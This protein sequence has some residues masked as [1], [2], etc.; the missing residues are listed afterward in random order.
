ME[1]PNKPDET[2][3]VHR[4]LF[5]D[6]PHK[7]DASEGGGRRKP[8]PWWKFA[9]AAL[10]VVAAIL[11]KTG[12]NCCTPSSTSGTSGAEQAADN[13]LDSALAS[14]KPVL[15][16]F[17]RGTCIPCKM[18]QPV[19]ESLSKEL[20]GKVHVLILD[21]DEYGYLANRY[22]IRIIPTQIFFDA[23]GTEKERHQGFMSKEEI[24]A[25]WKE[26]GIDLAD[27]D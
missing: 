1:E 14:G 21:T 15:A 26:L 11:V 10:I 16:D 24:L 3:P 5:D 17:G 7:D 25:K 12:R 8:F 23:S 18:M 20:E 13:P 2:T 4:G 19:L 6:Q 9:I 22:R 27:G